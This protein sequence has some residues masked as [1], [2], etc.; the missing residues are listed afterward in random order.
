MHEKALK[1]KPNNDKEPKILKQA[2]M[3]SQEIKVIQ[4]NSQVTFESEPEDGQKAD[5]NRGIGR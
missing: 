5:L 1:L 4:Q 3:S 2:P